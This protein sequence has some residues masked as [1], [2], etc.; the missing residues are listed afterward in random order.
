MTV[1]SSVV[2]CDHLKSLVS[3]CFIIKQSL[4]FVMAQKS[5]INIQ[6]NQY[7]ID[8]ENFFILLSAANDNSQEGVSID[9]L[10]SSNSYSTRKQLEKHLDE[11]VNMGLYSYDESTRRYKI[12]ERGLYFL[13]LYIVAGTNIL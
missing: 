10:L 3:F 9:H 6:E 12:T 2:H 8:N 5:Q 1:P 11:I 13:R 7:G 4:W